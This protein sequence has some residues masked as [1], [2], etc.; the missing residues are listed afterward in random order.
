MHG[1]PPLS[2][3]I[4]DHELMGYRAAELLDRMMKG[5]KYSKKPIMIPPRGVVARRSTD[6][7]A[8][9]DPLTAKAVR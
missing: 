4:L 3:V 7:V 5:K 1:N 8:I 2:S 6:V 9:D